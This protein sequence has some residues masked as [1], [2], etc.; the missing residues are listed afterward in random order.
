M[1]W[2]GLGHLPPEYLT[3]RGPFQDGITVRG[4][5]L[6]PRIIE[7][8][9][10]LG[11]ECRDDFWDHYAALADMVRPNRAP[12]VAE[13]M[14]A[15]SEMG[16]GIGGGLGPR[17]AETVLF[18]GPGRLLFVTS[19]GTEREIYAWIQSGPA[20]EWDARGRFRPSDQEQL[21]T[22]LCPDPIFRGPS[23]QTLSVT[24]DALTNLIFYES[25]AYTDRLIFP[26]S[27]GSEQIAIEQTITYNGNYKSYPYILIRGPL[28][29]PII[30]NVTTGEQIALTYAVSAGETVTIDLDYNNQGIKRIRNNFGVDLIGTVQNPNDLATFHLEVDPIAPGG[31]NRLTFAGSD[32]QEGVTLI[33]LTWYERYMGVP[34]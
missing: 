30:T 27:F 14:P 31:E 20:M 4:W 28:T 29:Y 19:A 7:Y 26:F 2:R 34:K 16:S 23:Q 18:T 1:G 15:G 9:L 8:D 22:W 32:A 10:W 25:P 5:K 24:L 21:L 11:G 12:V 17:A 33:R 3:D 6:P 13:S